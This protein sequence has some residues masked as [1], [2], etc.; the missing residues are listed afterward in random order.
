[1]FGDDIEYLCGKCLG[2]D[3]GL[4]LMGV[5][6]ENTSKKPVSQRLGAIL[7]RYETLRQSNYF[8]DSIK[9]KLRVPGDEFTLI[10]NSNGEWQFR[11]VQY[12]KR[13]V[14]GI[15]N[16]SNVWRIKNKF[17]QQPLQLRIEALMSAGPYDAPGNVVV[18]DFS[19]PK[20][21]AERASGSGITRDLHL[22][23]SHVKV[24]PVSGCY[25]ALNT[26]PKR[27][28]AWTKVEKIFRPPLDLTKQQGLGVWVYGDGQGEL[29]NFQ[30]R[31]PGHISLA[32]SEHYVPV[33]FTGWRYFE[34]I[35]PEGERYAHY[36]W[37]YGDN[38]S[39]YFFS[40]DYPHIES[41]SMW[42]NDLPP[43]K[44]VTCYLSSIKA[45]PLVK[46]TI[47]NPALTINNRTLIFPGQIESGCYLEFRSLSDCK[48]YGPE[49]ELL[50]E[51]KPQGEV[52]VL[53]EGENEVSFT[54]GAP[55][56]VSPRANVTVISQGAPL[57]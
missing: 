14:Q 26:G 2:A 41:L 25:S 27:E 1:M 52:P 28:G 33:D 10:Q 40:V 54:C 17:G 35:E 30:L 9:E 18:A 55:A 45:L 24:Q 20:A 13:K 56:G 48:L 19:D 31:S 50:S 23:S 46:T 36:S 42:Y 51:V 6:P 8:P 16:W 7:R 12:A 32:I 39:I 47:S 53:E 38:Y 44:Q 5:D 49:K 15:D 34:L 29:L 43:G 21:F 22:S 37:P 57:R 3:S 11:P 4:A